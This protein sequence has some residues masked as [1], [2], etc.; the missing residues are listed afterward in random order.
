MLAL[1]TLLIS[2]NVAA[3]DE[4]DVTIRGSSGNFASHASLDDATREVTDAASLVEPLPGV[5]VR[6]L[7][8]DDSFA[9]LS[10]R[11]SS[12]AQVAVYLAGVPLS[13]GADPTL[14]LATLPLW[15]GAR[16]TVH[17][18]FAP[19]SL[20]PGSLGGTLVLDPPSPRAEN[21]TEAW[22][23]L[24][25]FGSRRLRIGTIQGAPDG[26]R[27]A[28]GVSASR[29]DDDFSYLNADA[30]RDAGH[31]VFATRQNAGHAAA[32]G[33]ASVAIPVRLPGE[34]GALTLTSLAQ[35]R[36]Q[37]L[38]GALELPTPH[39]ELQSSRLL[40]SLIFSMP[41]SQGAASIRAWGRRETL[42]LTDDPTQAARFGQAYRTE[43]TILAAGGS[44]G[45]AAHWGADA[46]E[47]HIDGSG[48]RYEPGTY[49]GSAVPPGA[50]RG[51]AGLGVDETQR[52]E[53]VTLTGSARLDTWVDGA[54]G[55][56]SKSQLRPTGHVGVETP[57]GPL[58]IAA[59]AGWVSR[60]PSF[61]ER[62]GNRG[63]FLPNP[64]L[65]PESAFTVDGGASLARRVGPLKIKAELAGFGTWADDLI[66]LVYVD[67][68]KRAKATNIG[69]ARVFG[70]EGQLD[71]E[72]YG[73]DLRVAYTGLD[74][75][76]DDECNRPAPGVCQRPPLAGR[77]ATDVIADLA[78]ELN[79]IRIRYGLDYVSGIERD[80]AGTVEVPARLLHSASIRLNVPD[81][82][83]LSVT[84]D[85]RNLTDVRAV[86]YASLIGTGRAPIGDLY[87]YP[88]PGRTILLSAR[89]RM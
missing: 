19:A 24:G 34:D 55:A 14:D 52:L 75:F 41:V 64:T 12:S 39:Q 10:I 6:R 76:N 54:A 25:S 81:A 80:S 60:P 26:I 36:R 3:D 48:E 66:T 70:L 42:A 63:A 56:A 1:A 16:A 8:A 28:A 46:T 88:L 53:N 83:G 87:D 73:F 65:K 86:D 79:P 71:A 78:Y 9:T 37:E 33:I 2:R 40:E 35:M 44:V 4:D 31:D 82:P 69:N 47:F 84:L 22:G 51:S 21:A 68:Y 58:S 38:P 77:P 59:H 30:T 49:E 62:Y 45:W 61:V 72:V 18:T 11:G 29:S 43:D 7:G 5:H 27:V 57:F 13:G 32:S 50:T 89:F 74:T 20:G 67:F 15:P 23:A 17:R 85:I